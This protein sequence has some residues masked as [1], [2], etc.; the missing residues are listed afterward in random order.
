MIRK[1]N[2]KYVI[3][4][5]DGRKVLGSYDTEEAAKKRLRE[6]EYFKKVKGELKR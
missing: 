6:I 5:A 1:E 4:S 2:G 3:R